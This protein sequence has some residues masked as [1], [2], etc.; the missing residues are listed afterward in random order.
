[1]QHAADP[2]AALAQVAA[3]L[4]PGGTLVFTAPFDA[5]RPTTGRQGDRQRIGWDILAL[6][7]TAGLR[8]AAAHLYWSAEFGYLGARNFIFTASR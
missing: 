6:A 7:R 3:R 4:V 2:A 8:R 1:M 5:D